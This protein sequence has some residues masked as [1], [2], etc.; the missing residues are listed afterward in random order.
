MPW[1]PRF[2]DLTLCDFFLLGFVK[3]LIYVLTLPKDVDELKARIT[4]A[5]A[6]IDNTMLER[7]WQELDSRL[8]VCRVTNDAHIER[9]S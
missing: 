5:V 9:L 4:E 7:V 1:P 2:L 3:R 6:A 8:D